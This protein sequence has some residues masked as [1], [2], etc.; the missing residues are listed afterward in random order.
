MDLR[1]LPDFPTGQGSSIPSG[2]L[3]RARLNSDVSIVE[4]KF[5]DI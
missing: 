1:F 2:S 3:T 4:T 5:F